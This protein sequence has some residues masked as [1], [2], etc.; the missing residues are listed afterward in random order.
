MVAAEI[1]KIHT[2]EWTPQL[3]YDEPLYV[4]MNA[5]WSGLLGDAQGANKAI[6]DALRQIVLN[7]FGKSEDAKKATQW[8]SVFASGAG[9]LRT[10][11]QGVC[12]RCRCSP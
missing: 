9:H 10:G 6:A 7:D 11:Q 1:A 12:R 3:L 2:I 4:G 5:N 8:Y